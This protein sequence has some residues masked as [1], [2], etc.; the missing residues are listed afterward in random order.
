MKT[1][2]IYTLPIFILILTLCS[3]GQKAVGKHNK[4]TVRDKSEILRQ[5]LRA[6]VEDLLESPESP[7]R[8]NACLTPVVEDRQVIFLLSKNIEGLTLPDID[9]YLINHWC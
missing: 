2:N 4:L 5:T 1:I 7:K 3:S 8:F 9:N 6:G